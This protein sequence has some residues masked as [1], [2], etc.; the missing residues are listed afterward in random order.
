MMR[1]QVWA[2]RAEQSRVTVA[3]QRQQEGEPQTQ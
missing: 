1:L 2:K 3:A